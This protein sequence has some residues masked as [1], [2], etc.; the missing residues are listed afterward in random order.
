MDDNVRLVL[1]RLGELQSAWK[2]HPIPN[3]SVP[4]QPATGGL[5]VVVRN[6]AFGLDDVVLAAF[7]DEGIADAVAELCDGHVSFE[8]IADN[9]PGLLDALVRQH[10]IGAEDD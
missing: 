1:D 6:E 3:E 2:P 8:P 4:G 5:Y 9:D 7:A 10:R